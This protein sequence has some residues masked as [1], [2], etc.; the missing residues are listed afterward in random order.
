MHYPNYTLP[1]SP[2]P[3]SHP[4]IF[5][6]LTLS[7]LPDFSSAGWDNSITGQKLSCVCVCV[8]Q[9]GTNHNHYTQTCNPAFTDLLMNS[10]RKPKTRRVWPCLLGLW[11]IL[12]IQ[13]CCQLSFTTHGLLVC[14]VPLVW[15]TYTYRSWKNSERAN[16]QTI[17]GN[18]HGLHFCN[19]IA[20]LGLS[21]RQNV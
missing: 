12:L 17:L 16:T 15:G 10:D 6:T 7:Q 21:Y 3:S 11:V 4:S 18:W 19:Y 13:L 5:P 20:S 2:F 14:R 1:W 8:N 9:G